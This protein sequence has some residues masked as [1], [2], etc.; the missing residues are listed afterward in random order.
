MA[1]ILGYENWG[2]GH[3]IILDITDCRIS[4]RTTASRGYLILF[5]YS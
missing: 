2:D 1:D 3:T 4:L 5:T